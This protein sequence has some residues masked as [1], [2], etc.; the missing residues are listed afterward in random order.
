MAAG[1]VADAGPH[2]DPERGTDRVEDEKSRPL[3]AGRAGDDS[4]GLAQALDEAC[5]DDDLAAVTVE[6]CGGFVQSFG[7]EE[8]VAAVS[9][10]E[11]APAEVADR[12]TDVVSE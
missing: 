11:P 10:G 12:E 2:Q 3:H 4:V 5:D 6:E 7:G 1:E 9:P 8:D